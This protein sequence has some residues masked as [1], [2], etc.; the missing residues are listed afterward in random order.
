[1]LVKIRR[2]HVCWMLVPNEEGKR[3]A[4]THPRTRAAVA[5]AA[6]AAAEALRASLTQAAPVAVPAGPA[7]AGD[8]DPLGSTVSDAGRHE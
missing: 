6:A 3:A 2:H 5:A 4:G 1:M 8:A 7:V